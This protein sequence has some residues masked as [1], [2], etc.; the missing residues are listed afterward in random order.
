MR[1]G[2]AFP[3]PAPALTL[4]KPISASLPSVRPNRPASG[5]DKWSLVSGMREAMAR[6]RA[7]SSSLPKMCRRGR[8]RS[9]SARF[10]K[11]GVPRFRIRAAG[12]LP[13]RVAVDFRIEDASADLSAS[14]GPPTSIWN[15]SSHWSDS[16][17]R[18]VAR[19]EG[20][21]RQARPFHRVGEGGIGI[22]LRRSGLA[23]IDVCVH[24]GAAALAARTAGDR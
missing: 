13:E 22:R 6:E 21:R 2:A 3:G 5:M 23:R 15:L 19:K 12:R 9:A 11:A 20:R 4:E 24:L 14:G 10:A 17:G 7:E 18:P 1:L 8:T 16:A